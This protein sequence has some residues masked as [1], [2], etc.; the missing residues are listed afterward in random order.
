LNGRSRPGQRFLADPAR[1]PSRVRGIVLVALVATVLALISAGGWPAIA[2]ATDPGV[3]LRVDPP[4]Q[5]VSPGQTFIVNVIQSAPDPTTGAQTNMTFDPKQLQIKDFELGCVYTSA[6]AVFA[7]GNADMG[8][9]GNKKATIDRANK[10]GTLENA[11]GFLLPGSG[12]IPAG[13]QL[14][15]V[16]TFVAQT[17]TGNPITLGLGRGSMIGATGNAL[18]PKLINGSATVSG[19]GGSAGASGAP[20]SPGA[21]GAP[22]SPG[23]GSASAEPSSSAASPAASAGSPAPGSSEGPST[24]EAPGASP[25]SGACGPS[26]PSTGGSGGTGGGQVAPPSSPASAVKVS[27]APT[28]LTLESGDS[29][30]IFLIAN[31]DGDI[32]SV[33]SDLTFDKDKLQITAI[34]PGLSWGSATVLAGAQSEG[35]AA[36]ITEANSSGLLKQVGVF[37]PPG[38]EDLPYGEGDFVSVLVQAKADGTSDL[39]IGNANVLGVSG[40]TIS[41]TIDPASQTKPP[42][43][44]IEFDPV[45]VGLI[46]V[47]LALVVGGYLL[48]RSG[49]IPVRVRRRW[50]FYVSLVLGMIPVVMFCGL[51]VVLIVNAA[52]VV[53]N[54]GIPALFGLGVPAQS[55]ATATGANVVALSQSGLLPVVWGSILVAIVA[56]LISLPIALVLAIVAVDFP[57]GPVSR[58]VRPIISVLSGIPPIVYAV[59]VPIFITLLMIPKFAADSTFGAFKPA[60]IG[61]DPATWPPPDV[62]YSAGGLP[63]DLTGVANSTL[64]GGILIA[65]F[66]IPFVTPL[67]VDALSD[68]PRA[69]RE[70]SFALG[71]NRT[72]TIRRIVLPRALPAMAGASMLAVLKAL[73]DTFI[74]AFAIGWVSDKMPTPLF[75][76]LERTT[77]LAAQGAQYIGNF[78]TLD[79]SCSP[80]N[81][82]VG[83]STAL[84]LLLIAG[85][86][87]LVV[88]YLQAKSRRRVAV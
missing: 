75:D 3:S 46:V 47:I 18:D 17:G 30:R 21:S 19:S 1:L 52:P 31:S 82:A 63:W 39:S 20:A 71:A 84:L 23:A 8:T 6:N 24:S 68:V 12:N 40:E 55:S 7:F 13:D 57:M 72:Y 86:L 77:T 2:T 25:S 83:Y 16:V 29:A 49:R 4:T 69:A 35:V 66:L 54:P 9:A 80:A 73:G 65:L 70:A 11:A 58:I 27:V 59:S 87:V 33:A 85:I 76:L 14:F 62:P 44:G 45:L 15:L 22:A 26:Q 53:D 79:V 74:V 81:C 67:F 34:E 10:W 60:S 64:L 32:T 41:T 38:A 78:E 48:H 42:A 36:A 51:V 37:L 28:S 5:T 88:T 61:A 43:K 50:P 56:T